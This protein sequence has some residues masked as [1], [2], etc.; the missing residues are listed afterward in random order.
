MSHRRAI[1]ETLWFLA[2]AVVAVGVTFYFGG[3]YAPVGGFLSA[4]YFVPFAVEDFDAWVC[5]AA[6]LIVLLAVRGGI[7][8][9]LRR[10]TS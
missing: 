4:V 2:S 6:I 5:V 10:A 8:F 1:E 9:V 3:R 7:L